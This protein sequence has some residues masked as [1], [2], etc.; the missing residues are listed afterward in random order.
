[1]QK[2][3]LVKCLIQTI[4]TLLPIESFSQLITKIESLQSLYIETYR[5]TTFL[6][7]ATGFIIKSKT[8]NYLV[9]NYH[10]VTNKNPVNGQW[11]DTSKK[12]LPNKILVVQNGKKLGQYIKKWEQLLDKNGERY[13]T[14]TVLTMKW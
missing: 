8:Q 1:M 10:V 5:D 6:T 14:E 9:T 7:S 4:F 12:M 2:F 13:G 3:P 11:L